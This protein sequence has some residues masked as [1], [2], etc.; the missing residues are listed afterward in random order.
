V[1]YSAE[2]RG[3]LRGSQPHV[4]LLLQFLVSRLVGCTEFVSYGLTHFGGLVSW[5][6]GDVAR[7]ANRFGGWL[8][9]DSAG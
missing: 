9:A 4:H 6:V 8:S 5:W 1:V 3:Q 7:R 2:A